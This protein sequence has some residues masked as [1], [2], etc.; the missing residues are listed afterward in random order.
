MHLA[1]ITWP[2]RY[3]LKRHR[4]AK[5]VKLRPSQTHGL[6]I[7]APYR[8]SEKELPAIFDEHKE[9]IIKQLQKIVKD[10]PDELPTQ[11]ALHALNEHWQ[12]SYIASKSRLELFQRPQNEL[13]LVGKLDDKSKCRDKLVMWLRQKAEQHLA[14]L[15]ERMSQ[16]TQL[17]YEKI[18]VRDQKTLWGSCSAD[19]SLNF[20]YKLIFLPLPLMQH[21]IVHE[22][23]HTKHLN[24]SERFW[25][26]VAAFDP[27]WRDHKRELRRADKY[28]PTWVNNEK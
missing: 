18:T 5:S 24:H 28:V 16:H 20:N 19:K 17:S 12:V 2:P 15:V 3:R 21:V 13:V 11:L 1:D 14:P 27:A 8:F 9:W 4:L 22:L 26:L 23:C 6:D 10:N 25:N 7:T